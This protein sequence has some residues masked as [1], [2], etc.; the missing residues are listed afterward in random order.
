MK[1]N[2]KLTT[3]PSTVLLTFK[4]DRCSLDQCHLISV[5]DRKNNLFQENLHKKI[6]QKITFPHNCK[7]IGAQHLTTPKKQHIPRPRY[8]T[9]PRLTLPKFPL[10]LAPTSNFQ[11]SIKEIPV[12]RHNT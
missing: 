4:K 1:D 3:K 9:H 11:Y 2:I 5:A 12:F 6:S 8:N 10:L 7:D